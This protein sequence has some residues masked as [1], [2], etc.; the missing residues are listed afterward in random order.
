VGQT[1]PSEPY[2]VFAHLIDQD[3]EIWSQ[4]DG[5]PQ[6]GTRPFEEA[7]PGETLMDHRALLIPEGTPAGQYRVRVGVYHVGDGHKLQTV[8]GEDP[9]SPWCFVA[10]V[11]VVG[12]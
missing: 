10:D 3:G 1:P 11:E 6:N 12:E 4:R 9:Q 8:G 2:K 5:R 7:A